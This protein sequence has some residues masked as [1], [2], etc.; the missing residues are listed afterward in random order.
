MTPSKL[1]T[2]IAFSALL[3]SGNAAAHTDEYLDSQPSPHGGQVRM[4]DLYH[5]EMLV[6]DGDI[7]VYVMDHSNQP[8]PSAGMQATATV[9]AGESKTEVKLEPAGDNLLKGKGEFKPTDDLKVLLSVTP[10]PQLARFTPLQKPQAKAE[11]EAAPAEKS[12]DKP[13]DK[14]AHKGHSH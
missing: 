8:L 13:A 4:T 5:L 1:F 2:A 6:K 3:A 9:L 11:G 14:D 10:A 12:A 7:T